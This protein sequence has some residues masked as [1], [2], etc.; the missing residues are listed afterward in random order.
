MSHSVG[1]DQDNSMNDLFSFREKH[2]P[3][4]YQ[5]FAHEMGLAQSW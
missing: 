5:N 2:H 4:I 1:Q 3:Q